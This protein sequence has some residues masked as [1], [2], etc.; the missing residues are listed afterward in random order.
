MMLWYNNILLNLISR[1]SYYEHQKNVMNNVMGSSSYTLLIIFDYGF[2]IF[3]ESQLESV[4]IS[5][6]MNFSKAVAYLDFS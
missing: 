3:I 4:L 1:N 5:F 2:L 6:H